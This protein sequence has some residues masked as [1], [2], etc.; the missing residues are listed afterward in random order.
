[1]AKKQAKMKPGHTS[2]CC[3]GSQVDHLCP[4]SLRFRWPHSSRGWWLRSFPSVHWTGGWPHVWTN[5]SYWT[6]ILRIGWNDI[7][8]PRLQEMPRTAGVLL[9]GTGGSAPP[10]STT[11][12][13]VPSVLIWPHWCWQSLWNICPPTPNHIFYPRRELIFNFRRRAKSR[14]SEKSIRLPSG[15]IRTGVYSSNLPKVKWWQSALV[16]LCRAGEW[17]TTRIGHSSARKAHRLPSP[18]SSFSLPCVIVIAIV[19]ITPPVSRCHKCSTQWRQIWLC[20]RGML[21][22]PDVQW[23]TPEIGNLEYFGNHAEFY[24]VDYNVVMML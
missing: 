14:T 21:W 1:M 13:E 4:G 24:G 19:T 3:P 11:Y 2:C 18:T 17:G 15:L 22:P 5:K 9:M 8:M 6:T 12:F 7:W 16:E 23:S 10:H 20:L